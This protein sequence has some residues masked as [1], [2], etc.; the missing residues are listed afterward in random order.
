MNKRRERERKKGMDGR[1]REAKS[2]ITWKSW[3]NIKKKSSSYLV[4]SLYRCWAPLSL[5]YVQ[6][7]RSSQASPGE[8]RQNLHRWS[9]ST[10]FHVS[11]IKDIFYC[12]LLTA[13]SFPE[14][15]LY[16]LISLLWKLK[17]SSL[18]KQNQIQVRYLLAQDFREILKKF[19][20]DS[21]G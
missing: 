17:P 18:S 21:N 19:K 13:P 1:T 5:S 6:R 10:N 3:K 11:N 14:I 15:I 7:D 2:Q 20:W 16:R 8:L 4:C 12:Y 9:S